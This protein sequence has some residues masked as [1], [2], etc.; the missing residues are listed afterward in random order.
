[1]KITKVEPIVL[2]LAQVDTTRADGT[3]DAFLVRVHTDEGLVGVGEADTSPYVARTIIEMPSS[4]AV[5]RGLAELLMGEDPLAIGRLWREMWLGA[6]H[7]GRAGAALH[8]ISAIDIAL[9]DIAG[10]AAGVPVAELLGGRRRDTMTV[11]ASEVMPET[12]AEVR[13]LA[14]RAVLAGYT[15]LKLGWGPLG[16]SLESDME[17][18]A[19][20]R[21]VLGTDRKLMVDG[22]M[23]YSVKTA[24]RLLDAAAEL[25]LYWLEEPLAADD[26]TGY[27]RLADRSGIRIAAGEADSGIGPYRTLVEHGHVDVLQPDL[28]RCGGFTVAR[29]IA[30]LARET[31]VEVVPHCFSTGVLVAASLHFTATLDRSTLSEFSVADSPLVGELLTEPFELRDGALAIPTGPGLG[32]EIDDDFVRRYRYDR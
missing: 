13:A 22:G 9:W 11:Y 8:T 17:L 18:L 30:D 28:A 25:D 23:A 27:R 7:Y 6:Y 10:R 3:Q 26:Y 1:M 19:A 32:V 12:A 14:E 31:G 16:R 21:E 20:A 15:A 4:H 5:A 24:L 29:Q 2:R